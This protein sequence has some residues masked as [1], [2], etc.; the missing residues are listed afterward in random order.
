LKSLRRYFKVNRE[1]IG[2]LTFIIESYS[3]LAVLRT[4][5][6]KEGLIEILITP[7]NGDLFEELIANLGHKE[8]LKLIPVTIGKNNVIKNKV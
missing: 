3:G 1:D 8:K 5:D 6:S 4:I 7:Q 2:Y